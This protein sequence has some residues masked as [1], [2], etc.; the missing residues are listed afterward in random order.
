MKTAILFLVLCISFP[1][2]FADEDIFNEATK[3]LSSDQQ[4]QIKAH[5]EKIS[6]MSPTEQQKLLDDTMKELDSPEGKARM[7]KDMENM[8]PEKKA[9]LEK[10]MKQL[11]GR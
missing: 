11:K 2:A 6:K 4:A 1:F 3:G 7:K 9:E 5:I 10:M 8:P